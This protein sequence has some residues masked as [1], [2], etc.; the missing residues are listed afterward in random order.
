MVGSQANARLQR[1]HRRIAMELNG[2]GENQPIVLA[3][4]EGFEFAAQFGIGLVEQC[5]S[6]IRGGFPS[7]MVQLFDLLETIRCH[8][9]RRFTIISK[10]RSRPRLFPQS[11]LPAN[12]A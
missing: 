10:I 9:G 12:Q 4:E 8:R 11:S 1:G 6:L 2:A 3:R 7:G 5:G